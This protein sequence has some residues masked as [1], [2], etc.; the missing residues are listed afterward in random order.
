VND[1]ARMSKLEVMTK[2]KITPDAS[3]VILVSPLIRH[4][5]FV[6]RHF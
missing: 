5:S 1:E 4:S 6:I 3:F 2:F